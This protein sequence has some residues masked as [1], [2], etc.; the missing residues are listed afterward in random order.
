[1]RSRKPACITD[2]GGF[3]SCSGGRAGRI[4]INAFTVFTVNRDCPCVSKDRTATN[5]HNTASHS[6]RGLYPNDVWDMDFVS[7]ALFDGRRLRLLT[8]IALAGSYSGSGSTVI[9][10]YTFV[11]SSSQIRQYI[12][13]VFG[14][15]KYN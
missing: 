7:D 2:T 13:I 14:Q 3:T 6:L 15:I 5:Q 12:R 8:V 11:K 4:T 1:V 9:V 10:I